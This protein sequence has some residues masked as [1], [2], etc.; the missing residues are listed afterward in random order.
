MERDNWYYRA[1]IIR[2]SSVEEK[3]TI[4]TVRRRSPS[5][6]RWRSDVVEYPTFLRRLSDTHIT[7]G[8]NGRLDVRVAGYPNVDVTWYKDW[9]VIVPN[10]KLQV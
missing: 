7:V 8:H 2:E 6:Y 1:P 3:T 5:V 10:D 4:E 9:R